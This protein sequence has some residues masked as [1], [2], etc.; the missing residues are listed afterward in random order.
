[1]VNNDKQNNSTE[2]IM[3]ESGSSI[4]DKII[5]SKQSSAIEAFH[6]VDTVTNLLKQLSNKDEDI[7]RR[8][9]GLNGQKSET[10]EEIGKIYNVTRERIRQIE[11]SGIDKIK[12]FGQFE[13]T[14]EPV[15]EV[16]KSIL[17]QSGGIMEEESMMRQLL[18]NT[19]DTKINR[20]SINFIIQEL[21]NNRFEIINESSSRKIAW[22]IKLSPLD[23]VNR[24][25]DAIEEIIS[26]IGKPMDLENLIDEFRQHEIYKHNADKLNETVITSYIELSKNIDKNPFGEY[27]LVGWGSIVPKRMNDKIYLVMKKHGK[28]LHFNEI[29]KQVNTAGFDNRKAYAPTVHNELIL[30]D[31]YV[32]I[33]R[34]IYALKEW[35]YKPGVVLQVLIRVLEKSPIAL[36]RDDLV[37]R[38]LEQRVVKKNTIFLALTNKNYFTRLEDGKYIINNKEQN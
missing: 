9:F 17:E 25:I 24:T 15:A 20:N 23:L 35:G 28:P 31:R 10:L 27:G 5:S 38:V 11:R 3:N 18:I 6:P 19:G 14:V 37:K 30:N 32:L 34:G 4:L 33:G 13:T 21:L 16:I 29:T 26:K 1:M 22:H 8:R 12:S 36:S 7:I 2:E